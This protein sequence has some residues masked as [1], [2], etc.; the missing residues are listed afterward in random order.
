MWH[1]VELVWT[2]VSEE[3][4]TSIL[5]VEKS[6]CEEPNCSHLLTLVPRTQIFLPWRWKRYVPPKRWFTQNLHGAT[7]QK[8]A[9]FI[10]T[11]V[12][13][14]NLTTIKSY[15]CKRPWRAIGLW[16]VKAPTF[17]LD[18]WLTDDGKVVSL[19]HRPPFTPQEHSW[20]SFLLEAEST[21]G[22]QCGWKD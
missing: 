14:S 3:H 22:T 20:Y 19:A 4:I 1:R 11:A 17:S 15:P 21:P 13:T 7:S 6:A 10:V 18:N 9:F 16:D 5:R 8:T 12:K 2:D